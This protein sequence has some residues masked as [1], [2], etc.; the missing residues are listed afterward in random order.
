MKNGQGYSSII[1]GNEGG[2]KICR[3]APYSS[4]LPLDT[5]RVEFIR[6]SNG[7]LEKKVAMPEIP[8]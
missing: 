4:E 7:L 3:Y 6:T 8:N 1:E 5:P 2:M